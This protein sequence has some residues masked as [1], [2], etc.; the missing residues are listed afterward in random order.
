MRYLESVP[1]L[2]LLAQEAAPPAAGD[3][4]TRVLANPF[5]FLLIAMLLLWVMVILPNQR[6][7]KEQQKKLAAALSSLKKN[8]H[9]VT[10]SGIH[11]VILN[12]NADSPTVTIRIDESNNTKMTINRDAI[13]RVIG[14]ETKKD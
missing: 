4:W 9:V 8:D 5:N 12:A 3:D 13:V 10:S 2:W 14:D 1:N 11:G 7:A 6:Q